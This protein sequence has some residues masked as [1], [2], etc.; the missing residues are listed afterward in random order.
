MEVGSPATLPIFG[1]L[2]VPNYSKKKLFP[3]IILGLNSTLEVD[4]TSPAQA[5][6]IQPACPRA[7]QNQAEHK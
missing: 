7:W 5:G 6:Q 1:R 3:P 2:V 4:L